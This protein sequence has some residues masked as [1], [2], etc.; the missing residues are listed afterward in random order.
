MSA[1]ITLVEAQAQLDAYKKASLAVANNQSYTIGSI[2]FT[3]ANLSDINKAI[4][5]WS[6]M[7]ADLSGGNRPRSF[8]V[9]F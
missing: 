5:Y 7:V 6:K 9:V 8:P 3:R 1:G 2:T 4:T